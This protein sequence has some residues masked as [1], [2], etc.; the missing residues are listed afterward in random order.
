MFGR[1]EQGKGRT[2][3]IGMARRAGGAHVGG[4]CRDGGVGG[5]DAN[6]WRPHDSRKD[7]GWQD[8]RVREA[9]GTGEARFMPASCGP[10]LSAEVEIGMTRKERRLLSLRATL[11]Q[12]E[13]PESPDA[14]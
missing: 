8:A 5:A 3:C 13:A 1:V 2:L 4:A 12:I 11:V 7:P 14:R 6:A 9:R 10:D